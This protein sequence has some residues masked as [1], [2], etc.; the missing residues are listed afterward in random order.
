MTPICGHVEGT[1]PN[2]KPTTDTCVFEHDFDE[3]LTMIMTK[4]LLAASFGIFQHDD[5]F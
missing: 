1:C 3:T 2:T 5:D 4:M